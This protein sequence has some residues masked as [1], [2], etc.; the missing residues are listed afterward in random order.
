MSFYFSQF[1]FNRASKN[2]KIKYGGGFTLVETLIAITIL[3]SAVVGPMVVVQKSL[4]SANFPR[5]R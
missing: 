1:L 3:I 4:S 2:K 5:A